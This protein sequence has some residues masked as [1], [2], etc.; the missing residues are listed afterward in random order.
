M[1][2]VCPAEEILRLTELWPYIFSLAVKA[3]N[4]KFPPSPH[5]REPLF[6]WLV[7]RQS[8]G[9]CISIALPSA[10]QFIFFQASG[11]NSLEGK[12]VNFGG[13]SYAPF[14]I[15]SIPPPLQHSSS[16]G[17]FRIR[18][19]DQLGGIKRPLG[20]PSFFLHEVDCQVPGG[21]KWSLYP[22]LS[23]DH[24]PVKSTWDT[25][26]RGRQSAAKKSTLVTPICGWQS[27]AKS[28]WATPKDGRFFFTVNGIQAVSK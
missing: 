27:A 21:I 15:A 18:L 10:Y 17:N 4:L 6:F 9:H 11:T 25:P 14:G 24:P 16:I 2:R 12:Y 3:G 22:P 28:T 1:K 7:R 5:L 26:N 8:T 19:G 13:L 23:V 20:P